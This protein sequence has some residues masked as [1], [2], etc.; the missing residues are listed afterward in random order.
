MAL[1]ANAGLQTTSL[2]GLRPPGQ[3][4][5]LTSH[6]LPPHHIPGYSTCVKFIRKSPERHIAPW[7]RFQKD[8]I[9]L[10]HSATSGNFQIKVSKGFHH[11]HMENM[12]FVTQDGSLVW[13]CYAI[14]EIFSILNLSSWFQGRASLDSAHT[15]NK[16]KW[17]KCRPSR[18]P[19]CGVLKSE[20]RLSFLSPQFKAF[21]E[22]KH[23]INIFSASQ[24]SA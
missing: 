15:G 4:H 9:D 1:Q 8:G 6:N 11:V 19:L 21:P 22:P 3:Q 18:Q 10:I 2:G 5:S 14:L 13:F 20:R 23:S 7:P 17:P 12:Y 24:P 16:A